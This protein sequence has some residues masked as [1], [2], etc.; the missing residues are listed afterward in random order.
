[1][2]EVVRIYVVETELDGSN[3]RESWGYRVLMD[4]HVMD[5]AFRSADTARLYSYACQR[6]F[7]AGRDMTVESAT[8]YGALLLFQVKDSPHDRSVSDTLLG[9]GHGWHEDIKPATPLA[10]WMKKYVVTEI[11]L[12]EFVEVLVEKVT[13]R[14]PE[15]A[16]EVVVAWKKERGIP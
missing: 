5:F 14:E 1:M 9:W 16:R 7:N 6:L 8:L 15:K 12:R 3:S 10:A 13:L 4:G 11:E 2:A